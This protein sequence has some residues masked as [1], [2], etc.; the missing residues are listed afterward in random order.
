MML[1]YAVG[2]VERA[3]IGGALS[4]W[5]LRGGAAVSEQALFAIGNFVLN[6]ALARSLS[7]ADYG[8][9]AF[10]ATLLIVLTG[11]YNAFILEPA[12]VIEPSRYESHLRQYWRAQLGLHVAFTIGLG[13]IL[14]VV[15]LVVSAAGSGGASSMRRAAAHRARSATR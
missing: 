1:S 9:F 2:I 8:A 3:R 4:S 15:G 12:T 11:V 5:I 10:T 13:A 7:P 14:A 6:V